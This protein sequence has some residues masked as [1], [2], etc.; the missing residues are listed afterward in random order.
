M[1]NI[2]IYGITWQRAVNGEGIELR[3]GRV[4]CIEWG[5]VSS[6]MSGGAAYPYS[7]TR[8]FYSA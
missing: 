4:A 8:Y 1:K 6:T 2:Y 5:W 3:G 7:C